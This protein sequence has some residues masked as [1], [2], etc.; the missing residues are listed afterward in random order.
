MTLDQCLEAIDAIYAAPRMTDER[1]NRL[2]FV[3]INEADND[4]DRWTWL[5]AY[6]GSIQS[7]PARMPYSEAIASKLKSALEQASKD[8]DK[9]T[10]EGAK[11]WTGM[12]ALSIYA[13]AIH[14]MQTLAV[15]GGHYPPQNLT[16]HEHL[17]L[18][19]VVDRLLRSILA[20][21]VEVAP[22]ILNA[23]PGDRDTADAVQ[24]GLDHINK[25][26]VPALGAAA[27]RVKDDRGR[28]REVTKWSTA[29]APGT[30]GGD[31]VVI[32]A[33]MTLMAFGLWVDIAERH[34][35]KSNPQAAAVFSEVGAMYWELRSTLE[36]I[37]LP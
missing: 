10:A 12:L 18:P 8:T 1:A 23:N 19:Q 34:A 28:L 9:R 32:A 31:T 36:S 30:E 15:R 7:R 37:W 35:P 3:R 2:I 22:A 16:P 27:E 24:I 4:E 17:L 29:V 5:A 26:T 14:P 6:F 21:V 20:L 13:S 33:Y 25:I 11:E